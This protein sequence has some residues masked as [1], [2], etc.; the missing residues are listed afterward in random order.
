MIIGNK[1]RR[2]IS[3]SLA[4]LSFFPDVD[5]PEGKPSKPSSFFS[6]T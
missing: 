5:V 2:T 1:S 3:H 6:Q 4:P